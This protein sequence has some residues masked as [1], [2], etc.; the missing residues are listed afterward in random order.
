[1]VSRVIRNILLLVADPELFLKYLVI[2]KD[3]WVVSGG[4]HR[5]IKHNKIVWDHYSNVNPTA[6]ILVD[7]VGVP[8]T[9]IT[10]SY[11]AN[12]LAKKHNASI[13][14]FSSNKRSRDYVLYELF[15]SFQIKSHVK[16][17]LSGVQR[18][19]VK[20]LYTNVAD[21][22][23]TKKNVYELNVLDTW[24]GIDIY[25]TYLSHGHPTIDLKD[26]SFWEIVNEGIEL[27]IFWQ[28]YFK[29]HKVAGVIISHDYLNHLNI[30]A[31]VAYQNSVPV[32]LPNARGMHL[33]DK[34]HRIYESRFIN[35]PA[36]F[37]KLSLQEQEKGI[38][39][40][41][42]QLER[43]FSGEV[44]VDMHYSTDS[45]FKQID[46]EKPV[47]QRNDKIKVLI[48]TNCF[49]DNPH[50]YGGA[51]FVDFY[52]WLCFL[53]EITE[54]TDY[55]W[56]IKPHPDYMPGTL[57]ILNKII[58]KYPGITLVPPETSFHQL[59]KEGI[60]FALTS[61]G[62][63]GHELPLLGIQVV[64]P[65]YNPHVAYDFNWHSRT[66][67]EYEHLLMNLDKLDKKIDVQQLYE[68]YYMHYYYTYVDYLIYTSHRQMMKDLRPE[69]QMRPKAYEYFLDQLTDTKHQ[70]IIENMQKFID[71]GAL[72]FFSY[73]PE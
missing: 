31:K 59:G 53:G 17:R 13:K 20:T 35:Y 11:F 30:L 19:K 50:A 64:N 7:F 61:Y 2:L 26:S 65:G 24:I 56:Y 70:E 69:E 63:I 52:E 16:P 12:V 4:I 46:H 42:T 22:I 1:M 29:E 72:N 15:R 23:K 14:V 43:R 38:Q 45:A 10:Y 49:Y 9:I 28:D 27:L 21:S 3:R 41:K 25:E 39:K 55:D 32:Y 44:G 6:E 60:S 8:E 71:S 68:F 33:S 34:P 40:A 66:I 48:A 57:E 37:N 47:I 67:E 18:E 73:G 62:S 36:M 54:K 58:E 5:F 51:L